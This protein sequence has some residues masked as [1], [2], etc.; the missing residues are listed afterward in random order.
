MLVIFAT[1]TPY[2]VDTAIVSLRDIVIGSLSD[3][4]S[5]KRV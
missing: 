3:I 1:T 2:Y 4:V 5:A